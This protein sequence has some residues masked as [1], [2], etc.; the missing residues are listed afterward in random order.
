MW[1]GA[2]PGTEHMRVTIPNCITLFRI[3]GTLG[4][5]AVRPMTPVFFVL[6]T[7]CGISDA[8]DGWLARRLHMTSEFGARLDSIADLLF[9]FVMLMKLIPELTALLPWPFWC[10]VGA[11]VLVRLTAY[12][13]AAVKFRRFAALHTKFNKLTGLL[14]FA[15]PYVLSLPFATGYCWC[16]CCVAAGSSVHELCI[17]ICRRDYHSQRESWRKKEKS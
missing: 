15:L 1:H 16:V 3:A 2:Q 7:L 4:L 17:H 5:L 14:V 10:A 8:L 11:V 12:A 9:Y 6:Y 13:V